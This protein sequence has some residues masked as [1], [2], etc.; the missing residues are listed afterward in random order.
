MFHTHNSLNM[1]NWQ[2]L[3]SRFCHINTPCFLW[4]Y[5]ISVSQKE[6]S[7]FWVKCYY[8]YYTSTTKPMPLCSSFTQHTS[9]TLRDL[10][11]RHTAHYVLNV[12]TTFELT[13][14][15]ERAQHSESKSELICWYVDIMLICWYVDMLIGWYNI[16]MLIRW[17]VDRL[18]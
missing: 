6:S 8:Y 16:D 1:L 9:N 17:Y 11:N 5:G 15:Q 13:S 2:A 3:K 12:I 4:S 18:I 7:H 10:L 14:R